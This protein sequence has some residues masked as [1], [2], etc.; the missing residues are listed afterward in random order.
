MFLR[1]LIGNRWIPVNLSSGDYS[2]TLVEE[3]SDKLKIRI[4]NLPQNEDWEKLLTIE[5]ESYT[6][7]W[8][9]TLYFSERTE[10]FRFR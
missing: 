4:E 8:E 6:D 5:L 3:L 1:I 10:S 7:E 9:A 2:D